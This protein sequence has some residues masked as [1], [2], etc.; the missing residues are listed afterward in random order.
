MVILS[1]CWSVWLDSRSAQFYWRFELDDTD[2]LP[3]CR[4]FRQ[5]VGTNR[6]L[7]CY[8]ITLYFTSMYDC[9]DYGCER[10]P[11]ASLCLCLRFFQ[12]NRSRSSLESVSR[13]KSTLKRCIACQQN[14]IDWSHFYCIQSR[15]HDFA[16]YRLEEFF[17]H[18][19]FEIRRDW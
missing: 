8:W 18:E 7:V 19:N 14:L 3:S 16:R 10:E 5:D 15:L 6:Q 13:G 1:Y 11:G 4:V 2:A 17:G 12:Q 9:K